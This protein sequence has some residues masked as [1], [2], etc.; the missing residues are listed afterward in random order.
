MTSFIPKLQRENQKKLPCFLT[1][2]YFFYTIREVRR[3]I[4]KQKQIRPKILRKTSVAS[5]LASDLH[6]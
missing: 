6:R 1:S 3:S 5:E 4:W 2:P